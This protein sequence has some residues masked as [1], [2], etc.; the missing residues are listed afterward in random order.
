MLTIKYLKYNFKILI[1]GCIKINGN[2]Y[3]KILIKFRN[4]FYVC[5]LNEHFP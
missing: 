3:Q 4:P 5:A 2:S 1:T